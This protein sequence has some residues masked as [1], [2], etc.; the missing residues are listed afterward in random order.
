MSKEIMQSDEIEGLLS[1]ELASLIEKGKN[2]AVAQVNSILT[3]TYWHHCRH[4]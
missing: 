2:S 1:S 3:L 4:N